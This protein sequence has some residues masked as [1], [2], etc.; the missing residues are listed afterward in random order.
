M[1]VNNIFRF[2]AFSKLSP[3]THIKKHTGSSNLRLRYH[4]AIKVPKEENIRIRVGQT[5]KVWPQDK[6][7]VFD[8]SFEHEVFHNGDN[9]RIVLIVDLWHPEISNDVLKI[10]NTDEFRKFGKLNAKIL[11]I[12]NI[13]SHR[14]NS[15][16][17][18]FILRTFGLQNP[19]TYLVIKI[20][21]VLIVILT[22]KLIK[23][24]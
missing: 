19:Y 21:L 24:L 18:P 22:K 13:L 4:L 8:D 14:R 5:S 12:K 23:N 15:Q 20:D 6:C 17:L 1:P 11:V 9:E 16:S 2:V 3:G 10:F 7:I